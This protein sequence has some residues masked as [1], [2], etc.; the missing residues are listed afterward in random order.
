MHGTGPD[1][2]LACSME[3]ATIAEQKGFYRAHNDRKTAVA[4]K[5]QMLF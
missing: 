3:K 5:K 2:N 1:K 4:C